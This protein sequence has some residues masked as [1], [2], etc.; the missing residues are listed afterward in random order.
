[1]ERKDFLRL[2]GA[3]GL[4]TMLPG[5]S[6]GHPL[7]AHDDGPLPQPMPGGGCALIPSET[8]GPYPLDLSGNETY[9]RSDIREEQ[10]GADHRV[11]LRIV[12]SSNCLPMQNCRVDIWHCNADG[13]YSGYTTNAHSGQQNHN[14]ARFLRGIQMTDANGEV[15]FL[16]KFPGW[17]PG[18]TCHIHFQVYLNSMLQVTSQFCYPTAAKNALL[19]SVDPYTTWGADPLSPSQDGIFGSN[20]ALQECSLNYNQ[21]TGEYDSFLEATIQGSGSV[22]TGLLALEPET[23]GQFKLGQN[24]PNPYYGSTAIPVNLTNPADIMIELFDTSGKRAATIQRPGLQ[25]GDHA[26]HVDV[27]ALDIASGNYVYQLT[28]TNANGVY[29]QCK[30]MTARK[31]F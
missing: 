15:E 7:E 28:V 29:R 24:Y 3:A 14:N 6:H 13:Y 4:L 26:V 22:N 19:T 31:E 21:A 1:M 12:G 23:G 9:F 30:M 16:T 8:A 5:A 2:S 25:A 27:D 10:L 11:R 20:Y 17:Y 18:R